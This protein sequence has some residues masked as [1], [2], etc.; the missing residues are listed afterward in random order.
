[1]RGLT[2]VKLLFLIL[3]IA[4]VAAA[5][6]A[7]AKNAAVAEGAPVRATLVRAETT[8]VPST[9]EAGGVLRARLTSVVSS[10]VMAAISDVR[11]HAGDRVKHGQTLVVLDGRELRAQADRATAALTAAEQAV[12]AAESD[13]QGAGAGLTLAKATHDRMSALHLTRSATTQELDEAVAALGA[14]RA[15]ADGAAAR[16]VGAAAGLKAAQ[17]GVNASAIAVTYVT[18][19]AP[20]DGLVADRSV[21]PGT[22]VAPGAPLLTLEDT[23]AFRLEVR[24]DESRASNVAV[25]QSVQFTI[26]AAADAWSAGRVSEVSRLDPSG[27]GFVAKIDV[28][29]APALRSGAFGRAQFAPASHDVLT[30]PASAVIRRGQMTFVFAVDNDGRARLRPITAG[31]TSGARVELVAGVNDGDQL[32]DNPP[33]SLT[34]GAR[35]TGDRPGDRR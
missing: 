34:D 10:R 9:F 1:M 23:S 18:I 21:D 35:V 12:R 17:A 22:L 3:S 19:V 8:T 29:S 20:F 4:A 24:L 32:V 11:V 33:P 5:C 15:R 25:G 30:A 27:H 7:P 31:A 16:V 6:T 2:H 14:A 26:A 13:Q 28:P